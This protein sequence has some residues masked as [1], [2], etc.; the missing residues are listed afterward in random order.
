MKLK[1]L[2]LAR[3]RLSASVVIGVLVFLLLPARYSLLT[4]TLVSW[5]ITAWLYL[6]SLWWL[7]LR[8]TPCR[9][10]QIAR[11][12]DESAAKVL[13]LV[14]LTSVMSL[15]AILF[16]LSSVKHLDGVVKAVHLGLTGLTLSGAWLLVPTVFAI[17]YAHLFY[18]AAKSSPVL[19]FPDHPEEPLYIDFLYFSFTIAVASQTADVA[20]GHPRLR[21]IVLAQSILSFLFNM[22]ILGLSINIGAGLV[23]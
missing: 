3:P 10:R 5:D 16:E 17:H 22:A 13:S 4:R 8:A 21:R 23:A 7:M 15:V 6:I 2:L 9:I 18:G 11:T 12:Q 14:C 20:V 1:H 19:L